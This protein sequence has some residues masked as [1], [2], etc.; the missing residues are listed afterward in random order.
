MISTTP[1]VM[2]T[3]AP[4]PLLASPRLRAEIDD[5]DDNTADI[6]TNKIV[7]QPSAKADKFEKSASPVATKETAIAK[8]SVNLIVPPTPKEGFWESKFGTVAKWGIGGAAIGGISVFFDDIAHGIV[9]IFG[10]KL[11]YNLLGV[12]Q[13][14]IVIG[15]C[16]TIGALVGVIPALLQK[17][18]AEREQNAGYLVET[19]IDAEGTPQTKVYPSTTVINTGGDG[20][21][22]SRYRDDAYGY[23]GGGYY[24][25]GYGGYG[26][27]GGGY[28]GGGGYGGGHFLEDYLVASAI[29]NA[30][31]GGGRDYH[32]HYYNGSPYGG[33]GSRRGTTINNHHYYGDDYTH[34]TTTHTSYPSSSS[35]GRSSR[36]R[37]SGGSGGVFKHADGSSRSFWGGGSSGR[38][39]G[40]SGRGSSKK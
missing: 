13:A 17:S 28:Y 2:K 25:G 40:S 29:G 32:H 7:V 34:S 27:Y 19:A 10:E 30:I 6:Q 37:S 22:S 15:V 23:G 38:G 26:G 5:D 3:M 39:F 31:S 33:Y 1:L 20:G 35:F 36:G 12:Q 11:K 9:G 24:G 16:A 8:P 21:Y 14:G 4:N 18:K